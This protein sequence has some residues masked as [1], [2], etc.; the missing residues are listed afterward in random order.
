MRRLLHRHPLLRLGCA[1]LALA[2]LLPG[3]A[4][5]RAT[6]EPPLGEAVVKPLA[7]AGYARPY[8]TLGLGKHGQEFWHFFRVLKGRAP[9]HLMLRLPEGRVPLGLQELPEVPEGSR[10]LGLVALPGAPHLGLITFETVETKGA[11]RITTRRQQVYRMAPRIERACTLDDEIE[12]KID[13][14]GPPA[15]CDEQTEE[16]Q[17]VV[18]KTVGLKPAVVLEATVEST[19]LT[20]VG[21]PGGTC[22]PDRREQ[23]GPDVNRYTIGARGTCTRQTVKS[24]RRR[25]VN[26]RSPED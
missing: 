15:G 1:P 14:G 6:D 2:V 3:A 25:T 24:G 22:V 5:V 19:T 17:S 9:V 12:T 16:T 10:E 8:R 23:P 4:P 21:G 18:L 26:L 11:A 7:A 20:K 13:D